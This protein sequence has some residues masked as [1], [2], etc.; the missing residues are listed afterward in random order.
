MDDKKDKT[1]IVK[2]SEI[3]FTYIYRPKY[4]ITFFDLNLE[5]PVDKYGVDTS[6]QG[7]GE[8]TAAEQGKCPICGAGLDPNSPTPKCPTHG[9]APF[10]GG[11]QV[12]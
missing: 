8:K 3:D 11:D 12:A 6:K 5:E 4:P 7:E 9:T 10:E 1:I 2:Q